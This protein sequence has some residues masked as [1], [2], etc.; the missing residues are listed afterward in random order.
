MTTLDVLIVPSFLGLLRYPKLSKDF[1]R[2][3]TVRGSPRHHCL[4]GRY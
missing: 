3:G 1:L 2:T 4:L